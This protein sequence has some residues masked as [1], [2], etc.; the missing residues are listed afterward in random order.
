MKKIIFA[1]TLLLAAAW[2][3]P[4]QAFGFDW[5]VTGGLNLTKLNFDGKTK[6]YFKS[7]NQA[8]W[9][10]GAKAHVSLALG[11]GLDGAL[12]YSQQKY[13]T[14]YNGWSESKTSRSI[15]IP[16]NARYSIGLGSIAS[17]YLSTGPQFDFN[18]GD[19]DWYDG[20]FK[21]SNMTTSWNVGA[22]VKLLSRLEIGLGYNF[23]IGDVGETILDLGGSV[24]ALP[25]IPV[26]DGDKVNSNTFTVSATVYF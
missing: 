25:T 2:S 11:F 1:L 24:G 17:V 8:G 16:L 4:A 26:G 5:G 3:T 23:G 12:L 14:D 22:G 7:D 18:L 10:I 21:Q 20:T 9:F 13:N 15:A 6:D 19:K